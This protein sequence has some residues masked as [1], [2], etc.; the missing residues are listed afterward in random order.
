[1]NLLEISE[2]PDFFAGIRRLV[3]GIASSTDEIDL[4]D[5]LRDAAAGVGAEVSY[6]MTFVR[7]DRSF[8]A[9]R[10]LQA[11]DPLWGLE[12]GSAEGYLKDP[13][14]HYAMDHSEP[15]RGT[16]IACTS[17]AQLCLVQL[18]EKF[19]F[20]SVLVVPAPAGSGLSR[21]GVLVLGSQQPGFFEGDGYGSVKVLVRA[22]AMELHE[23][24]AALVR[25]EL[26]ADT[27]I[28]DDELA[29]LRHERAGRSSKAIARL[30]KT[31]PGAVDARFRRLNAKLHSPNKR[32]SVR[33]ALEYGLVQAGPADRLDLLGLTPH[34]G[35]GT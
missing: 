34:R 5:R 19:G 10:L 9:Y 29:L 25:R 13:W 28:T 14:L 6:F 21:L 24:C 11:C 27:Q 33:L 4:A 31:T 20:R 18:A 22:I 30:L 35:D 26:L 8:D 12:Y 2:E 17:E 15:A 1:M 32:V 3:E 16:E 7:E 23:R